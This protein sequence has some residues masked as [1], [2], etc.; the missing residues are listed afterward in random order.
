MPTET[1]TDSPPDKKSS[2]SA[3]GLVFL[4][5]FIDLL[6]FGIVLPLLPRYAEHFEATGLQLS[7]LSA[8]FSAMQFLFSPLWGRLSDRIG[9]RPVLI[10]GLASTAFFYLLFGLV[11]QWGVHGTIL[12]LSPL[13]WLFITRSGAGISGATISTAQAYIA[14]CT[15]KAERGKGM[16]LIGAAFGMGFTFGPLLGAMFVS[17]VPQSTP[18]P[19]P[20]FAAASLS[21]VAFLAALFL[22]PESL[23]RADRINHLEATE[24]IPLSQRL[25]AVLAQPVILIL[26]LTSFIATFAF[27][28]FE[29][30]LSLLTE[31]LGYSDR[32]NFFVFAVV[33]ITL[34]LAQGLLVRRLL[35]RV[36][37]VRM[38]VAGILLMGL[39]LA[40]VALSGLIS[41]QSLLWIAMPVAVIGFAATTPSLQ[42]LL[43]LSASKTE[44]GGTLG[45]GQSASALARICGPFLGFPLIEMNISSPYFAST[46]LLTL[47]LFIFL[48]IASRLPDSTG[49]SST[50]TAH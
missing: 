9:R 24:I 16:A 30:T 18:T 48:L 8:S 41:Q 23:P 12:G 13:T 32:G 34:T 39:G 10:F 47:S 45:L 31:R 33:G 25:T 1:F 28:I 14:D 49:Q 6:G 20:A 19:L 26:L 29:T 38:T 50:V 37:E 22:L 11:T 7:M 36:G 43:S 17:S 5:V 3:L 27:S 40:G 4:T 42:S 35:P 46:L 15:G 21:L 2:R 44:Q